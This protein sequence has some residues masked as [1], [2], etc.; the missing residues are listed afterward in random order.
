MG[1]RRCSTCQ[2]FIPNMRY[3]YNGACC[4]FPPTALEMNRA[5]F[6]EVSANMLCGEWVK[7]E[8]EEESVG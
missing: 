2:Y 7:K 4:R 1:K 6:P 5:V 8:K 3:V